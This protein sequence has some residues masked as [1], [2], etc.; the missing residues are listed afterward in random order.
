MAE[1]SVTATTRL[2]GLSRAEPA[3]L[4]MPA[5]A[6]STTQSPVGEAVQT[7]RQG[8]ATW[9][10]AAGKTLVYYKAVG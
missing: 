7:R 3:R 6:V 1:N 2:R 4:A 10:D 9:I 5:I 8:N